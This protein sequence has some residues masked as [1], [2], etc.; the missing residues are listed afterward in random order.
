MQKKVFGSRELG[1]KAIV[2]VYNAM[3]MPMM[4]YNCESWVLERGRRPGCRH[5][6]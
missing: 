5:Q 4:T 6:K 1:K 3:V 2:E